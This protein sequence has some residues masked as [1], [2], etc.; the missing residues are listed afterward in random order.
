MRKPLKK[1]RERIL[2]FLHI[3]FIDFQ[4]VYDKVHRN[5]LWRC[6]EARVL[7]LVYIRP[8]KNMD[9]EAKI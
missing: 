1:Y 4:K 8:I 7:M 2:F 6:L 5:M 9:N 3:M